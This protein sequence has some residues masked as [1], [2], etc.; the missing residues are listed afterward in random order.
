MKNV[1][2]IG[3][4][5][6]KNSMQLHGIDSAGKVCLRK[7]LLRSKAPLFFAN[8]PACLVGMEACATSAY[9]ARVIESCGHTVH[10]I[11]PRFVKPYLMADKNDAN[12]AAAVCEAVQ[13][14]HMRFVPH[15]TQEQSDIQAMHRVRKGLVQARTAAINQVRGLLAENG[16]VIKQGA[17]HVRS[18]LPSII[19]DHENGLSG[20]M[21][22]LLTELYEHLVAL[23]VRI[24]RQSKVLQT[25]SKEQEV[26]RRLME[27]PGV[28]FLTA[29][30]L[31]TVGGR[32]SDF[33][34]GREFAAFLGLVPRQHSTGGKPRMLGIT[35]RGN[36]C[37]RTLLIHGARAVLRSLKLG[38]IPLGQGKEAQWVS[39]MM[40]R[41]GYN[42]TSVGLANK[43]ARIAW[44]M[45][46]NET[47]YRQAA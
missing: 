19:E 30:I 35:K 40:E 28:G 17:C 37:A 8:L 39:G 43:M 29:T 26:C 25:I 22:R 10:R 18:H 23:D 24:D 2:T 14:P 20:I 42:K 31:L 33:K 32:P 27:I 21:R 7:T 9:W 4:D 44:S 38:R 15:K 41:R 11:H 13:R 36:S 12:D 3:I 16:I 46:A 1:T 47:Q 34:N 5:L 6:A 45:M